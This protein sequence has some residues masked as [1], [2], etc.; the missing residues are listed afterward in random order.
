ME[1]Q[2]LVTWSSEDGVF[3]ATV[4][5]LPGCMAHGASEGEAV[6]SARQAIRL[7]VRDLEDQQEPLP[8]AGSYHLVPLR[9]GQ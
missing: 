8:E 3:V 4:P 2:I 9:Q 1:Y 6:E 7:Y 5:D